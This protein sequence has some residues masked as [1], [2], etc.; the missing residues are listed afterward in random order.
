MIKRNY[1]FLEAIGL[2]L[3]LAAWGL[4]WI[5]VE[6]WSKAQAAHE[7]IVGEIRS[8]YHNTQTVAN[9][10]LE[11]AINRATVTVPTPDPAILSLQPYQRVWYSADVRRAWLQRVGNNVTGI[12]ML[13]S[14]LSDADLQSGLL[15][16]SKIQTLQ[17]NLLPIED[18]V[19][20]FLGVKKG[21]VLVPSFDEHAL[22]AQDAANIELSLGRLAEQSFLVASDISDVLAARRDQWTSVYNAVFFGGSFLLIVAKIVE[23]RIEHS[24]PAEIG[25]PTPQESDLHRAAPTTK[26]SSCHSSKTPPRK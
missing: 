21:W 13:L 14:A 25:R 9:I 10:A 11:S 19:Q 17:A 3:A 6:R 24:Q 20:S 8:S 4:N 1:R 7:R 26:N 23:W 22:S 18:R 2:L 5:S 12:H 15:L 16:R